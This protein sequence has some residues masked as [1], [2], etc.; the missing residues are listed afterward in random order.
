MEY[1]P[2][3]PR[4][5]EVDQASGMSD[6]EIEEDWHAFIDGLNAFHSE[7]DKVQI[8]PPMPDVTRKSF[9]EIAQD[10]IAKLPLMGGKKE[11]K[12]ADRL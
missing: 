6:A 10:I 5:Y 3:D 4:F 9:K 2:V 11:P 1:P 8:D 12:H 7:V